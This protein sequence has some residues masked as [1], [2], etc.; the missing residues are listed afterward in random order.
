MAF[1][2]EVARREIKDDVNRTAEL[3]AYMT[4]TKLAPQHTALTLRAAMSAFFKLK[5]LGTC[6]SFCRRLL[7]LDVNNPK[8]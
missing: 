1:R 4:H 2:T 8:V 5:N 6:A 3:A 7:D